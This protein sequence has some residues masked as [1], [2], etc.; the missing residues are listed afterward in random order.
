MWIAAGMIAWQEQCRASRA[1]GAGLQSV[2]AEAV[3]LCPRH[4]CS[5]TG[6][7]AMQEGPWLCQLNMLPADTRADANA[8][9]CHSCDAS[10]GQTLSASR[11]RA[12]GYRQEKQEKA[13]ATVAPLTQVGAQPPH[14][15]DEVA[16]N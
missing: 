8:R 16:Q 10:H 13:I 7:L 5:L 9:G 3:R 1:V 6:G 4:V 12:C 15:N 2:P 14:L 11:Q